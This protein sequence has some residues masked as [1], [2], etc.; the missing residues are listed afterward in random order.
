MSADAA[1]C[2]EKTEHIEPPS[3]VPLRDAQKW[4]NFVVLQPTWLPPDC[5]P[6]DTGSLR[7][8]AP[9]SE[10]QKGTE[11]R[12]DWTDANPSSISLAIQGRERRIRIKQFLYDWAPPAADHPALWESEASPNMLGDGRIGWIGTDYKKNRAAS[13]HLWGTT[14]ETTILEGCFNDDELA[15]VYASFRPVDDTAA[16][17]ILG[18]S[19]ADLSY[20]AR[21][22]CRLIKVP[23]GLWKFERPDVQ[24]DYKW[25][26]A[27]KAPMSAT[28]AFKTPPEWRLDSVCL[29][30]DESNP[31]QLDYL[32][33]NGNRDRYMWCIEIRHIEKYP[34]LYPPKLDAHP[35]KSE[36]KS[37][38]E[39]IVH[40]AWISDKY[41][42]HDALWQRDQ[43][44]CI[45]ERNSATNFSNDKFWQ[46]ISTML[47]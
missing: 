29:Y 36:T 23:Y 47:A 12:A 44:V 38:G 31:D 37:V 3:I 5:R 43:R 14:C 8:E 21:Y 24:A 16:R 40:H 6:C 27:E 11:G 20:W 18:T 30:G 25:Y 39:T 4:C 7:K 28:S 19:F 34:G 45:V 1:W 46:L 15:R 2:L 17:E 22:K 35:C 13:A 26:S 32:Y 41:G 42:P 9:P 10:R 33:V